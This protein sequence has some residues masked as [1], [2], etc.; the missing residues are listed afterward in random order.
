MIKLNHRE[1]VFG[2]FPNGETI[3]NKEHFQLSN[4]IQTLFFKYEED[5]DLAK[6]MLVKSYLDDMLLDKVELHIAYMPYSR[7]DRSENHSPF[8]LKYV[9]NFINSLNFYAVTVVE[10]HSDV[11]PALLNKCRPKY[12]NF[13]LLPRV[14]R[15]INFDMNNDYLYFPDA[16]ASKRYSSLKGY[17]QLVGH[18]NRDFQ[19]GEIKSLEVVGEIPENPKKIL[20]VDDLSSYGGTFYHSANALKK[21]GF[22]EIYLLVAHAEHS[23]L[24]GKLF[25]GDLIEKVFT[26]NTI[27]DIRNDGYEK[28]LKIYDIEEVLTN[29]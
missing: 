28:K 13:K 8:T 4:D 6:L 12:I 26:T 25:K 11:T 14:I 21:L 15:E 19:T 17:K 2:T 16:G 20:I 3:V 22:T 7:M 9:A 10:P 24:E 29:G 27:I 5:G 1:I 23:I 18:K